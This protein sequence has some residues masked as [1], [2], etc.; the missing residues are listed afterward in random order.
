MKKLVIK[1][2]N[3][4][5]AMVKVLQDCTC[6]GCGIKCCDEQMQ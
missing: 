4:C 1:K 6:N 3:Q 2:C 5:G